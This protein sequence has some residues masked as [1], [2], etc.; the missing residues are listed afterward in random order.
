MQVAHLLHRPLIRVTFGS[1]IP[2][3]GLPFGKGTTIELTQ[4]LQAAI[5]ELRSIADSKQLAA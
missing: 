3:A 4:Q 2:T 1:P 5:G